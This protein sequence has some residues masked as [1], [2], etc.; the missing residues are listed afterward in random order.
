MP[1]WVVNGPDVS[2]S[3][4]V[5]FHTQAIIRNKILHG[6]NARLRR[7]GFHPA[8]PGRRPRLDRVKYAA[9]LASHRLDALRSRSR[10]P[11][12]RPEVPGCSDRA[13][14]ELDG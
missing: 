4:S 13:N 10:R 3:F 7:L 2:V 9:Y 8:P 12:K 6:G 5:T 11:I 1:H 14:G